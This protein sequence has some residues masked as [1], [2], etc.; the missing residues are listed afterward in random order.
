MMRAVICKGDPTSHGGDVI[1]GNEDAT[2]D[3]RPIA[4]KGH[5]THCPKC[6][7]N[8]PISEGVDFHT[9]AGIGTAVE[10]MRTACGAT[11]IATTTK[12]SMLI[13]DQSEAEAVMAAPSAAKPAPAKY[14]G[15]FRAVDEGSGSPVPG[16]PY[17]I[18]LPD[19]T[20]LR[21]VTNSDGYTE[22]ITGLDPATARL[23]WENDKPAD[24]D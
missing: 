23:H 5:M 1:E 3:G 18:E 11:L 7:G 9:Y 2:T 13:D 21:G 12:D 16:M 19:G 22:R 24:P 6:K 20:T 4:Q 15:S 8:F 14:A 17:R 10:G